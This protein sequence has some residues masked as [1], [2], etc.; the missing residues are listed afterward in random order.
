MN[1]PVEKHVLKAPVRELQ[2]SSVYM[3]CA[4]NKPLSR[5]HTG[6]TTQRDATQHRTTHGTARRC[7]LP[8][9]ALRRAV[10]RSDVNAALAFSFVRRSCVDCVVKV[11][12]T[13]SFLFFDEIFS[14][15]NDE[16]I[17]SLCSVH[18]VLCSTI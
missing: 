16:Q 5:V 9:V 11:E 1:T 12:I 17:K 18:F 10:L 14:L 6:N 2:F 7:A 15:Q 8:S 4:V 3:H 13:E